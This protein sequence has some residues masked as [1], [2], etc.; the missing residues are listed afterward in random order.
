MTWLGLGVAFVSALAVNWAYTKEHDAAAKLPPVSPRRPFRSAKL[1][2]HDRTWL[3]GFALESGG[4]LLYV[5]ALRLAP[6]ALVQAVGAGGIG[7]LALVGAGG[8]PRRLTLRQRVAVLAALAGLALLAASLVGAEPGE[9]SPH[10][11]AV[12]VWLAACA[13]GAAVLVAARLPLARAAALGLA[14]GLL[15][16]GGDISVKLVVHGGLWLVAAASLIVFYGAGTLR[17][18][19]AFQ[20]GDAL[21]AAGVAT[22]ATYA[23]P[24]AAGFSLFGESLPG[25]SRTIL[26]IAGFAA[27]VVGAVA[28][29]E[30]RV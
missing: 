6:L 11:L 18:Q 23:V 3:K 10:P 24:I 2:V 1:L 12:G 21:T 25:G 19:A 17:L 14:A 27:V 28:L 13:G 9:G 15:F 30:P 16:A 7:V 26:Q 29:S 4:W 20:Q 22:L 5:A 8:D